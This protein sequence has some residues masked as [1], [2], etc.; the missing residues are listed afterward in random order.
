MG[1]GLF[2]MQS[3]S[4]ESLVPGLTE[5]IKMDI[6][7]FWVVTPCSLVNRCLYFVNV[8]GP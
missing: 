5:S 2:L 7:V 6:V 3:D 4:A 8:C 1:S